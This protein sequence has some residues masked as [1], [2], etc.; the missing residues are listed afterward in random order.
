M[1]SVTTPRRTDDDREVQRETTVAIGLVI[2]LQAT[3][4]ITSLLSDWTL[5]GLPGWIW[6][7]A[8]V[9]ELAVGAVLTI[10]IQRNG[11][12]QPQR[13]RR[14]ALILL[15]IVAT[16]NILTLGV[17]IGALLSHQEHR[18]GE[19]LFKAVVI[20]ATNVIVFGLLFWEIDA[21][22]PFP[23]RKAAANAHDFQFPQ[24]ENPTLAAPGWHPRLFDYVYISFT[25]AIAFSPTDAMPLTR[26]MKG[27][28]LAES[29]VSVATV[30][31]AAAR[32]VNILD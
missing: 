29:A 7:L 6:F 20:W 28:M 30:L 11:M 26:R 15:A 2:L 19:L 25:N 24:M 17:L 23:R 18:G 16:A 14:I 13:R 1:A 31:L 27:L 5:W 9:P 22:G 3:L 8:I 21:G 32:A 10:H 4:A 12:E